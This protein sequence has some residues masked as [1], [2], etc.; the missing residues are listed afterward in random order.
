[1]KT[2]FCLSFLLFAN[3]AIK[4]QVSSYFFENNNLFEVFPELYQSNLGNTPNEIM[5][6]ENVESL[7]EE[8][9]EMTA[10]PF[11][12]GYGINVNYTLLMRING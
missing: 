12:F 4:A 5:A 11:R 10:L 1:M 6:V 9:N 2:I 7:L 3:L 8:D